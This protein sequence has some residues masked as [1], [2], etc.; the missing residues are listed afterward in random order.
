MGIGQTPQ[1]TPEPYQPSYTPRS[2]QPAVGP[3]PTAHGTALQALHQLGQPTA[4]Q[5]IQQPAQQQ[6]QPN[7][8]QQQAYQQVSSVFGRTTTF[9]AVK[10][11]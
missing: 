3:P 5:L 11:S 10:F 8:Q 9:L 1:S 7:Q 4:Q 2:S 6:Q